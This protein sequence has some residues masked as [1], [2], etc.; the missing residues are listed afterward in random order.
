MSSL[1]SPGAREAVLALADD[2]HLIGARHTGWIG[3]GPFLEED[4]AFCSIAQ[5]ELGHAIGL[6]RLLTDD[7]D[8]LGLLRR[9]DEYRSCWL[10]EWPCE[11]WELAL[12]RHWLYDL[13]ESIR[14]E[15]LRASSLTPLADLSARA[16][17][18]ESFHVEHARQLLDRAFASTDEAR[19]TLS[20]AVEALLPL[21]P[22]LWEP[23]A[24]EPEAV[25]DGVLPTPSARL[26]EHHRRL[27]DEALARWDVAVTWPATG[28]DQAARTRRSPDFDA[29]HASLTEVLDLDPSATW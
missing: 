23:V 7:V 16:L 12:V 25:A 14:W 22:G 8:R 3:L 26:G 19:T 4:L 28:P 2:E 11:S 10:A 9:P 1:L 29:F 17:R 21:V 13:G 5:D 27:I 6:Y 20:A 15:D 24:G 18:E